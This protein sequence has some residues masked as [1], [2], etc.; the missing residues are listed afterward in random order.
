[1]TRSAIARVNLLAI[2]SQLLIDR[3][4]VGK[5]P[6]R[7]WQIAEIM[8][9]IGHALQK[10]RPCWRAETQRRIDQYRAHRWRVASPIQQHLLSRVVFSAPD[11]EIPNR[12]KIG[13]PKRVILRHAGHEIFREI[14]GVIATRSP[15]WLWLAA[16]DIAL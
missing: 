6:R 9:E 10:P 4:R 3:V 16:R 13:R 5:R 7:R 14:H 12:R 1:M 15:L 11:T 8:I 2:G